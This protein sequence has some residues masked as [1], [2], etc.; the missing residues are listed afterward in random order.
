MAKAK[1]EKIR[2][3]KKLERKQAI[4]TKIAGVRNP[5]YGQL[6]RQNRKVVFK[7]NDTNEPKLDTALYY[8]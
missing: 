7:R 4:Y 8:L 5:R 2:V 1:T 3:L 6:L